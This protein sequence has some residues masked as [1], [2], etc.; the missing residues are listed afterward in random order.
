MGIKNY[1]S[2]IC[3]YYPECIRKKWLD[4]YDYVFLDINHCLHRVV[5]NSKT[6][7]DIYDK[8]ERMIIN[9]LQNLN[10]LHTVVIASDG[11]APMA[12]ILLQK[13]RR[14]DD[15]RK[16]DNINFELSSLNFTPGTVFMNNLV[17]K[18]QNLAVKIKVMFSVEVEIL[19]NKPDE[20]EIKIKRYMYN[21]SKTHPDYT[22]CAI[23]D[24]GDVISLSSNF[25]N[26]HNIYVMRKNKQEFDIINM[27]ILL[28]K[29][30]DRYGC[31]I[32]PGHD[33]M[34][35]NMMLGNDYLPKVHY[36]DYDKIWSGYK[37]ALA[38]GKHGIVLTSSELDIDV[39]CIMDI[40][41]GV[42]KNMISRYK[43]EFYV[44][45]YDRKVCDDYINGMLWCLDMYND[46][47]CKQYDYIYRHKSTPHCYGLYLQ[48]LHKN[49]KTIKPFPN[50]SEPI[51][52]ELYS[53][54]L[55]PKKAKK[56]LDK[57]YHEF[58]D[59]EELEILYRD[60]YCKNCDKLVS[61]IKNLE[62]KLSNLEKLNY[63][64]EKLKAEIFKANIN[65]KYHRS[66]HVPLTSKKIYR[67]KKLF[68]RL[69]K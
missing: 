3:K 65:L 38:C 31:G 42:I 66:R 4:S 59:S 16:S 53:I 33:F 51:P 17:N 47:I 36:I 64:T 7:N 44:K 2:F 24:D 46:G 55:I 56:M 14:L 22:Q 32:N 15:V 57:K 67:I 49:L 20:A 60:E 27:G 29:H 41:T 54:I 10:P 12:K 13:S 52:D 8:L 30:T 68:D 26:P 50:N 48:L 61:N 62:D 45:F 6:T 19:V 25:D 63:N 69:D 35:L 37:F 1:F 21:I 34:A 11:P 18:I 23:S 28:D 43:K 39:G 9:I 5:H 58:I 40:M